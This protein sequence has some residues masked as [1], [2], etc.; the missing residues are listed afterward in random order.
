[1]ILLVLLLRDSVDSSGTGVFC[2]RG[3][4]FTL[5]AFCVFSKFVIG[6]A[7]AVGLH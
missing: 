1:M 6:E 3:S 7:L 5:D 2:V 4:K